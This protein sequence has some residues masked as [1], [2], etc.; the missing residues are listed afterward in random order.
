MSTRR[1][2]TLLLLVCLAGCANGPTE[3]G[4]PAPAPTSPSAAPSVPS[5]S[6]GPTGAGGETITGTVQAGVEPNCLLLQDDKGSHLLI[7]RDTELRKTAAAGTKVT[8]TGKSE[9]GMMSTCQQGI[10][11][12]V[13]AVRPG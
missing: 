8:V 10:P 4:A 12:I 11:F 3:A 13:S 1:A 7:I 6:A 9:P 2:V 5:A